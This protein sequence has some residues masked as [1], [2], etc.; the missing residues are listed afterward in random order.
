MK[1]SQLFTK[2]QKQAPADE[3]ARNAQ[4]LMRG[5]FIHKEMAGVYSFLPLGL[6]VLHK[7]IGIIREE[8]NALGGQELFLTALQNPDIWEKS[9]R[10]DDQQVDDWFKTQLKN[11]NQLGLG[12]THE[13]PLTALLKKHISSYKDLPLYLY[14][15]Q[16]KFR[17]ELRAKS[18][19]LRTREFIMKDLYS[20]NADQAGLDKFYEQ[21]KTTYQKIFD[22]CGLGQQTFLTFAAGGSFAKYSH[23]FQTVCAAGEDTIYIDENKKIAVNKEVYNDEVLKDLGLFKKDLKE[24]RSIEVGNIFQLGTRFSKPLGLKYKDQQGQEKPVVMGSYG[25]GPARLMGTIVETHHD[26]QGILWP[27]SVAPFKIHLVSLGQDKEA[28]KIYQDLQKQNVEVLFD[29]RNESPGAK[30]ADADLLG[31]PYRVVVSEKTLA[32]DGVELKK[33]SEKETE[34]IKISDLIKKL[35]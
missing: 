35:K 8:M 7:I 16:T 19:L 26:Q 20:F 6:R 14:Q 15:F 3:T 2:T 10:W 13:E 12:F 25:I 31:L 23:E 30:F 21:A 5:G 22:R 33:R 17:N 18:G 27:A 9:G 4:L 1:Q 34:P 28:Q 24:E 32:E 11:Q 29:D